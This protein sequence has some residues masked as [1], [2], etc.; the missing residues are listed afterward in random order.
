MSDFQF[1]EREFELVAKASVEQSLQKVMDRLQ[2]ECEGKSVEEAKQR[3]AKAWEDATDG[4][5]TDPELTTYA[6]EL[7]VG[8]RVIIRLK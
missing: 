1:N 6:K 7:A 4:K 8:N 5:I 2:R 3:L